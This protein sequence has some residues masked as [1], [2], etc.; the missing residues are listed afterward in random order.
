MKENGTVET[1]DSCQDGTLKME[2]IKFHYPSKEDV[3]VLKGVTIDVKKNQIVALVG[4]SGKS[5]INTFTNT[6]ARLTLVL[7]TKFCLYV[8]VAANRLLF[9]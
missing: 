1:Q 8:Q 5:F 2:D 4:T 6:N 3:P 9:N 7:L